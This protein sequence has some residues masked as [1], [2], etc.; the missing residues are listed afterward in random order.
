MRFRIAVLLLFTFIIFKQSPSQ[1]LDAG[2]CS[3]FLNVEGYANVLDNV[4]PDTL[5][6]TKPLFLFI[7]KV[8]LY[9]N[10]ESSGTD[11]TDIGL[12]V[13]DGNE[14]EYRL[15]TV[16]IYG[17]S[18]EGVDEDGD[19]ANVWQGPCTMYYNS[20][21]VAS[22]EQAASGQLRLIA[23]ATEGTIPQSEGWLDE[24]FL[25]TDLDDNNLFQ[26]TLTVD[27][28]KTGQEFTVQGSP[29]S[30]G[31]FL[32][33]TFQ[34]D[35]GFFG[36]YA[37]CF[38]QKS[39][40]EGTDVELLSTPWTGTADEVVVMDS[41]SNNITVDYGSEKFFQACFVC[42]GA[43]YVIHKGQKL[44]ITLSTAKDVF[45]LWSCSASGC[46]WMKYS[47]EPGKA[48]RIV[49]DEKGIILGQIK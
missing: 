8:T 6:I 13:F 24:L 10:S 36:R 25:T 17:P 37:G 28:L 33:I 40:F 19:D 20:F 3:A 12:A 11:L 47:I 43:T 15:N 44:T 38:W 35:C 4:I 2:F 34:V 27:S 5:V 31:M 26:T 16:R 7:K 14:T 29:N 23:K 46:E 9:E 1:S 21:L 30:K 42:N 49:D 48:Y 41:S 32:E 39:D 18:Y 45:S 22:L